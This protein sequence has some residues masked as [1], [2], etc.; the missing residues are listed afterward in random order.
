[1]N[2]V[3]QLIS[4]IIQ[5]HHSAITQ[6][7]TSE[8]LTE[9]VTLVKFELDKGETAIDTIVANVQAQIKR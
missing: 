9:L 4:K 3:F 6:E 8:L 1:M 2:K 5:S 7:I